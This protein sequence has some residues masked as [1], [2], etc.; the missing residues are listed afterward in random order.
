MSK[1]HQHN[2]RQQQQRHHHQQEESEDPCM[3]TDSVP[4]PEPLP[5]TPPVTDSGGPPPAQPPTDQTSDAATA[6]AAFK[7]DLHQAAED[8]RS[9]WWQVSATAR[10]DLQKIIHDVE[11]AEGVSLASLKKILNF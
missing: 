7:S 11:A 6:V 5:G 1:K 4:V 8:A 3:S 2:Q 9:A 10:A